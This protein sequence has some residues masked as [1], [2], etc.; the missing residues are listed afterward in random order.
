[1]KGGRVVRWARRQD[2]KGRLVGTNHRGQKV[3][4]DLLDSKMHKVLANREDSS[5]TSDCGGL[6]EKRGHGRAGLCDLATVMKSL[7]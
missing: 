2:W 5:A 6:Q 3:P 1:M 4:W 7:Q